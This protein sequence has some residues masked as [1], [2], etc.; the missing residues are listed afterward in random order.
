MQ[1]EI[2]FGTFYLCAVIS[3]ISN[4]KSKYG[5]GYL[6][7]PEEIRRFLWTISHASIRVGTMSCIRINNKDIAGQ[8]I[9][10]IPIGL[11][12]YRTNI[13]AKDVFSISS[14]KQFCDY[15]ELL[16]NTRTIWSEDP[17][18]NR[19]NDFV[20]PI[21]ANLQSIS[22]FPNKAIKIEMPIDDLPR[23][24]IVRGDGTHSVESLRNKNLL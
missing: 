19:E 10:Q 17:N 14:F 23:H 2:L 9:Q 12:T 8:I 15:E 3:D 4:N 21:F 5:F 7:M 24:I 20:L 18:L 16:K 13:E 6:T 1:V 11:E 22:G